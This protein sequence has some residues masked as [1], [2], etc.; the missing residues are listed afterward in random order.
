MFSY[1]EKMSAI[2]L[3]IL[4]DT[5][6]ALVLRELGYPSKKSYTTGIKNI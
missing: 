2:K 1:E 6:Y 5:N 3:L 4:Y